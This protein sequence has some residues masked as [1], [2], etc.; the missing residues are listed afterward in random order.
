MCPFFLTTTAPP[1]KVS[2]G[3][4]EVTIS[5]EEAMLRLMR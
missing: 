3:K 5:M 2:Q 1:R 4:R